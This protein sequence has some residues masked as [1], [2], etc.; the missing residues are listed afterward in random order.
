MKMVLCSALLATLSPLLLV[1]CSSNPADANEAPS[2]Q[3][4]TASPTVDDSPMPQALETLIQLA[5]GQDIRNLAHHEPMLWTAGQLTAEQLSALATAGM[6]VF[7]SLRPADENGA[8]WEE[9]QLEGSSAQFVRIPVQGKMGVTFENAQKLADV[10][11]QHRN[12]PVTVYCGS[13]N[14]VGALF[15]LSAYKADGLPADQALAIGIEHG[16]SSLEPVV[17][18]L[19]NL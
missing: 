13:S 18:G 14:R 7:I 16:L 6:S 12:E 5:D 19:L 15:A 1:G 8:G 11:A 10:L 2:D 17:R 9:T 3:M 4:T